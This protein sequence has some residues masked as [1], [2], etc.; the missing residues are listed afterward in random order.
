MPRALISIF[1]AVLC[2]APAAA[3]S[4]PAGMTMHRVQAGEPDASGWMLAASTEGGFSVRIPLKFNDFTLRESDRNAPAVRTYTVGA[5]SSEGIKFSATRIVYRDGAESARRYFARFEKGAD[6]KPESVR[7]RSVGGRRAVDLV[8]RNASSVA[9]QRAVL[10]DADL[11]L[12]VLE[13]PRAYEDAA[14][15]LAPSFLDSLAIQR[16]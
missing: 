8:L 13:S 15:K 16:P 5:K 7:P 2:V 9:Y 14:A 11:V 3:Q 4:L 1:L 10:L 12:V 6:L